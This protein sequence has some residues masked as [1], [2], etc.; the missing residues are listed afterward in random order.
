MRIVQVELKEAISDLSSQISNTPKGRIVDATARPTETSPA[1]MQFCS[2]WHV[3]ERNTVESTPIAADL[4][5]DFGDS[6]FLHRRI[7]L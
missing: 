3:L 1:H 2:G 4:S 6:Q 7:S 5:L